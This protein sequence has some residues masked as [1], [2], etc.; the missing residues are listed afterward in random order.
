MVFSSLLSSS[1]DR[2][3]PIVRIFPSP[4]FS[5]HPHMS[6]PHLGIVSNVWKPTTHVQLGFI[7]ASYLVSQPV[8]PTS[9]IP[10]Q[11]SIS[12]PV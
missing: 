8:P 1:F 12:Q 3:Q 4:L 11:Q 5:P 10:V 2:G 9:Q 6:P 7:V